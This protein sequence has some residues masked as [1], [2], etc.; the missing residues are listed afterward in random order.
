MIDYNNG[1]NMVMPVGPMGGYGNGGCGFGGDWGSWIILFLIFGMFGN[2]GWGN[3]GG[4]NGTFPWL[5][6]ANNQTDSAVRAGFDQAAITGQLNAIQA[7]QSSAEIANCQRTIES[8][9]TSY[10]NQIAAMNQRFGDTVAVNAKIDGVASSLQNCCC[11]NRQGIANL[12]AEM[13]AAMNSGF[14]SI[15]DDLCQ[16]KIEAKNDKIADLQQQLY[17]ANLKASQNDQTARI[18]AGQRALANEVEQYVLPT[19]RPAYIVQNPNCCPTQYNSCG[20]NG[21]YVA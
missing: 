4:S 5:L 6:N 2:N 20:C 17:F 7:G 16:T 19:A 13:F 8:L 9:K 21:Q 12:K 14:Q 1:G 18:E 3:N 10:E 15:K 11:E